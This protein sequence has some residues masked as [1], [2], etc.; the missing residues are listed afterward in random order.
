MTVDGVASSATSF[1]AGKLNITLN[2][3]VMGES[4]NVVCVDGD[5]TYI[6]TVI[7]AE[8]I[9][10]AAQLKELGVGG[11]NEEFTYGE[12]TKT[13]GNGNSYEEG[14]NVTGYY[15]LA[16]DI[17][18]KDVVFAAGYSGGKSFFKAT[19]DGNGYTLSNVTV[20]E[21][22]IFGGMRDATVKNVRFEDVVY[23]DNLGNYAGNHSNYTALFAHCAT[24]TTFENV[25]IDVKSAIT[26]T[27]AW[28]LLEGLF[29]AST[30]NN[31]TY[32]NITVN[33][34]NL[35]LAT[36]LGSNVQEVTYNN[37]IIRAASYKAIGYTGNE[38]YQEDTRM[39][40]LPN[41]PQA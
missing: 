19:L 3:S 26:Q 10:T 16:N 5:Y 6:F 14:N 38:F 31:V 32:S 30:Q 39:S 15:V 37:V 23:A 7:A 21:G 9:Y 33:A 4:Y 1:T 41:G 13:Y 29:V 36:V 18:C 35:A 27:E 34:Q 24:N 25:T 28:I 22:G 11:K 2:A 8:H 12:E 20:N 17:D 40:F